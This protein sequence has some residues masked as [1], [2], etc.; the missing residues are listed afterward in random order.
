MK[1]KNT[2]YLL[3]MTASLFV[4]IGT[5]DGQVFTSA[6]AVNNRAVAASPRAGEAFPWLTRT[7]SGNT[8]ACGGDSDGKDEPVAAMRN[9]A[10]TGSPRVRKLFP[11]LGRTTK[12]RR[13]FTIAPLVGKNAAILTNPRAREEFP[14]LLRSSTSSAVKGGAS[15]RMESGK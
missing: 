2:P 1:S 3:L 10:Y 5:G 12:P 11:E 13:D 8:N 7:H 15:K 6:D 14:H 4:S 9:R